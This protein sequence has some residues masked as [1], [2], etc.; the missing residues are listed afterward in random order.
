MEAGGISN[1]RA[2]THVHVWLPQGSR[3]APRAKQQ[4]LLA[5]WQVDLGTDEVT[6]AGQNVFYWS[7]DSIATHR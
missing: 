1:A 3:C 5:G 4:A 2:H 7:R 6:I